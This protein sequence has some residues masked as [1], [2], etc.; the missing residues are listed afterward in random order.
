MV[1]ITLLALFD[2]L[3]LIEPG[4]SFNSLTIR[5]IVTRFSIFVKLAIYFLLNCLNPDIQRSYLIS[6]RSQLF[7]VTLGSLWYEDASVICFWLRLTF[8][9]LNLS[10]KLFWELEERALRGRWCWEYDMCLAEGRRYI[11]ISLEGRVVIF[12]LLGRLGRILRM[13]ARGDV[14]YFWMGLGRGGLALSIWNSNLNCHY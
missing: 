14:Y 11:L 3:A 9:W 4:S 6:Y 12:M 13:L 2:A 1:P 7:A 8:S 10:F 5:N